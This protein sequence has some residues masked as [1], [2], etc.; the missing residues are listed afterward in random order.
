[1][2]TGELGSNKA[3]S[4]TAAKKIILTTKPSLVIG[5]VIAGV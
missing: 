5:M 2:R 4:S 1:M 3:K